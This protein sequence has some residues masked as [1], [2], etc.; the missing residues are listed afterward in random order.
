MSPTSCLGLRGP[1]YVAMTVLAYTVAEDF[2][3]GSTDYIQTQLTFTDGEMNSE[4]DEV[5]SHSN[6]L[7]KRNMRLEPRY[8]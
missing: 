5:I 8:K 6:P 1:T 2:Q 7:A 4:E 3:T